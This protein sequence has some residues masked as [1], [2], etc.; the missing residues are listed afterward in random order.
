M[1]SSR[2]LLL[3]S[4]AIALLLAPLAAMAQTIAPAKIATANPAKIFNEIQ[5]TKDLKVAMEAKRK[6]LEGMEFEK[7]QKIKD[8]QAKRDQLQANTTQ[9]R[10]ANRDLL[11]ASL[12]FEVWGRTQQADVQTEQK[13]QMMNL[14]NKITNAAQEVATAK[15]IDLVVA[16]QRPE[17]PDN[18]DQINVDQLRG[19]INSRNVLFV[20]PKIDISNEIIAA[21]DA[22]FK[23]GK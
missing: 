18:I 20:N 14:F 9:W 15:G 4:F 11:Q 1:K 3:S 7:R 22:K 10:D 13:Q 8:L 12:E 5:E 23:T 21:M 2:L 19:L 16:E 17:F 6:Q